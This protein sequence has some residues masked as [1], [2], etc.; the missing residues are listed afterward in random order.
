MRIKELVTRLE[1]QKAQLDAARGET[2]RF[3]AELDG[4][5]DE[6][7]GLRA[8]LRQMPGNRTS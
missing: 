7:V 1:Q 6:I 2:R 4:A 8:A 5:F 3:T